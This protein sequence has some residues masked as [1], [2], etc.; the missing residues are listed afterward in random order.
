VLATLGRA[1]HVPP[2]IYAAILAAMLLA[3]GVRYLM[4]RGRRSGPAP[5]LTGIPDPEDEPS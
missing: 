2:W 4:H 3:A 1:I 5:A